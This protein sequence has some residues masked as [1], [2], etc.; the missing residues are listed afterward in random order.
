MFFFPLS[1][2]KPE[3]QGIN[4]FPSL[5]KPIQ[6]RTFHPRKATEERVETRLI[7]FGSAAC[8]DLSETL[9][10]RKRRGATR[11]EARPADA[12]V[13]RRPWLGQEMKSGIG[14]KFV[15]GATAPIR[16]PRGTTRCKNS[17]RHHFRPGTQGEAEEGDLINISQQ[18]SQ[19]H[20]QSSPGRHRS[21]QVTQA[22]A[23]TRQK[24]KQAPTKRHIKTP[25]DCFPGEQ[26]Y[27]TAHGAQIT[28]KS[29]GQKKKDIDIFS[30]NLSC[31]SSV[32]GKCSMSFSS[33]WIWRSMLVRQVFRISADT[34]E[35]ERETN[36]RS[37]H[38]VSQT[39]WA[40][41]RGLG[42]AGAT[43]VTHWLRRDLFA[44]GLESER[45]VRDAYQRGGRACASL[46]S[47][48]CLQ[49]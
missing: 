49:S 34:V 47:N 9:C 3:P 31:W 42:R 1:K 21:R 36:G 39:H 28:N 24:H 33:L 8:P 6:K 22:L 29:R 19:I 5:I 37:E 44:S 16:V 20:S 43:A 15:W 12:R 10:Y 13:Q 17:R 40:Q 4:W 23:S 14:D 45:V 35:R 7:Q 30:T 48:R 26:L 38:A 41:W 2:K 27:E 46:I 25:C 32:L 11:E 18:G